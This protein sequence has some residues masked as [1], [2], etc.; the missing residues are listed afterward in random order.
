MLKRNKSKHEIERILKFRAWDFANKEFTYF[1]LGD[2]DALRIKRAQQYTGLKDKNRKEIY[3]GDILDDKIGYKYLVRRAC[4]GFIADLLKKYTDKYSYESDYAVM[5][6]SYIIGNIYEN[7][8][9]V[10]GNEDP[11]FLGDK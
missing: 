10:R 9:L 2:L 5:V 7:P 4:L 6:S 8:E 1:E 3:E 11:E